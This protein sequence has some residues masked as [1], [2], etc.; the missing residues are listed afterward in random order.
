MILGYPELRK[1]LEA[2]GKPVI[3]LPQLQE[4][5]TIIAYVLLF[6][7]L[8]LVSSATIFRATLARYVYSGISLQLILDLTSLTAAPR[9]ARSRSRIRR[10]RLQHTHP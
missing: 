8:I 4:V 5:G 2:E 7:E 10:L 9:T 6:R 3:I 1:R